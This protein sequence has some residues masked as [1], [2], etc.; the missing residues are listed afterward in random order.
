[1]VTRRTRSVTAFGVA[2]RNPAADTLPTPNPSSNSNPNLTP[3]PRYSHPLPRTPR[4]NLSQGRPAQP[5][6][7]ARRAARSR[8][9][10]R[11]IVQPPARCARRAARSRPSARHTVQPHA[12]NQN[13]RK[14]LEDQITI[15]DRD[16]THENRRTRP[17][18]VS[19]DREA[20]RGGVRSSH[21]EIF[22]HSNTAQVF[23]PA[24]PARKKPRPAPAASPRGGIAKT[25]CAAHRPKISLAAITRPA[26]T[27]LGQ[28]PTANDPKPAST[29]SCVAHARRGLPDHRARRRHRVGASAAPQGMF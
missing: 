10:A 21:E 19:T 16:H 29:T 6:R 25:N 20:T 17:P 7:R 12:R 5:A 2:A 28:Q 27:T 4:R 8:P 26:P 22:Q 15:C 11:H 13:L 23:G 1:M 18:A 24:Y 14:V 9:S 3:R